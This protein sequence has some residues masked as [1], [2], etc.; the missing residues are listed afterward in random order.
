[1]ESVLTQS[2][3]KSGR[4]TLEYLVCDGLSKDRTVDIVQSF[5]SSAIEVLSE[6][7]RGMYDALG[8]GLRRATG[9][10]VAYINAGDYYQKGAF[11]VVA[12]IFSTTDTQWL[13]G[14][15][16]GCD[17]RS[18]VVGVGL[19]YRYR[20]RL[21]DCG[22]YGAKLPFVQ[23]E[24][25]FWRRPLIDLIDM[26]KLAGFRYA[27]DYYLWNRF[28][29][30]HELRIVEAQLGV[31]KFH[32]GQLS[33]DQGTYAGEMKSITRRRNIA[34]EIVGFC[35]HVVWALSPRFKKKMNPTGLYRYDRSTATWR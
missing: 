6:K 20:R 33:E 3:V 29:R 2:A 30:A 12:D 34:D 11:D 13:T 28:A 24:S 31:F 10:V 4:V 15:A 32:P 21:F 23:Q 19:P 14:L 27:G 17:E 18:A 1:M 9:D 16:S 7:D 5:G 22:Y 8:K 26:D 25:T 35:D